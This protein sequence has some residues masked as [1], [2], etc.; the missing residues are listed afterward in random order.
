MFR[1][2]HSDADQSTTPLPHTTSTPLTQALEAVAGQQTLVILGVTRTDTGP[3]F[4][5]RLREA[6]FD[7]CLL[8]TEDIEGQGGG[9]VASGFALVSVVRRSGGVSVVGQ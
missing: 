2:G 3:P 4:F 7:Y 1:C 9:S 6:G 5:R 8:R